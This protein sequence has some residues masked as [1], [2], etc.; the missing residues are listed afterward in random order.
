MRPHL[1]LTLFTVLILTVLPISISTASEY[2]SIVDEW[3]ARKAGLIDSYSGLSNVELLDLMNTPD[4]ISRTAAF[5]TLL[6]RDPDDVIP[7]LITLDPFEYG[8]GDELRALCHIWGTDT[9]PILVKFLTIEGLTTAERNDAVTQS[10]R[11]LGCLSLFGQ[12]A[13]CAVP[14]VL[15]ALEIEPRI[16]GRPFNNAFFKLIASVELTDDERIFVRDVCENALVDGTLNSDD[17]TYL[18]CSLTGPGDEHA[19][20]I[21]RDQVAD[22]EDGI[23][24]LYMDAIASRAGLYMLGVD[25][26]ETLDWIA[27]LPND[28]DDGMT[29]EKFDSLVMMGDEES[30][31][32]LTDLL[33]TFNGWVMNNKNAVG[34]LRDLGPTPE[35][36]ECISELME[37]EP[38]EVD[39]DD[40]DLALMVVQM[41]CDYDK[42]YL[43]ARVLGAFGEASQQ[44][45]PD[46]IDLY[47]ETVDEMEEGE[48]K[49]YRLANLGEM[50]IY[51]HEGIE[52]RDLL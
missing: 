7:E 23:S 5:M 32:L 22:S 29:A 2:S 24:I 46:L 36:F 3:D 33:I 14:L 1:K 15:E 16:L 39:P 40:E 6:D 27:S 18:Y 12:D 8:P 26:H 42:R 19:I 52:F 49:D 48:L 28:E 11:A 34:S 17:I 38:Y 47:D 43:T 44:F 37:C 41:C 30:I 25:R 31:D 45:L 9:I 51:I 13:S 35:V 4:A 50:I 10:E 21:M 20:S